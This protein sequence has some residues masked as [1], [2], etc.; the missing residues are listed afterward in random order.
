MILHIVLSSYSCLNYLYAFHISMSN[1]NN[2]IIWLFLYI[3]TMGFIILWNLS[4]GTYFLLQILTSFF[5][6][7]NINFVCWVFSFVL[8]YLQYY[9]IFYVYKRERE[10][11]RERERDYIKNM[12]FKF[13]IKTYKI[14]LYNLFY[15]I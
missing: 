14:Y 12:L 7:N 5:F 13:N 10:R 4:I 15:T 1:E 9:M 2:C 3:G 11:E 8:W 6:F